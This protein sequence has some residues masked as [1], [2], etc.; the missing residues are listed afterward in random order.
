[1][2][3]IFD[4]LLFKKFASKFGFYFNDIKIHGLKFNDVKYSSLKDFYF[5]KN[6]EIETF[7][8]LKG[9]HYET[10]I[11]LGA[12]FGYFS[13]YAKVKS[14]I[15][16]VFAYEA[17]SYNFKQLKKFTKLNN[18]EI[19]LINKAVGEKSGNVKFYKPTYD[20]NEKFPSHGQLTD[21]KLDKTNLYFK[22]EFQT[23][24]AEMIPMQEIF[25]NNV[26]GLTLIKLDIEG[27]EEKSLRSIENELKLSHKVDLLVEILINDKNKISLFNFLKSLGY[28]SYLLTN[29]GLIFEDRP[30]TLPKP[31]GDTS[32][33]PLRTL[34]KDHLFTKKGKDEIKELNNKIFMYNV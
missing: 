2:K 31:Y 25:K 14:N 32:K 6:L 10:F 16:N 11:D 22:K 23:E 27:Y 24:K 26:K 3:K 28:N 4:S 7:K 15:K 19:V 9:C 21:P 5:N 29:A 8:F 30:L 12:Y 34:W 18:A 33:G 17:S 1:M 20:K 13:I